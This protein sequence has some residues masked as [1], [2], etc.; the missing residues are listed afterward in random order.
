MSWEYDSGGHQKDQ[1]KYS[2]NFDKI[3][4]AEWPCPECKGTRIKG[5]N[6]DCS[7]HWRNK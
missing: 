4:K 6:T 7:N 1:K 3:F 5:H 2:E